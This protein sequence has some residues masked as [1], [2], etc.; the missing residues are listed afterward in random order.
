[1]RFRAMR[2]LGAVSLIGLAATLAMAWSMLG[3]HDVT[4][5]PMEVVD[6]R[7]VPPALSEASAPPA[8]EGEATEMAR[9]VAALR[10][11]CDWPDP[12]SVE[13][14][15]L[16]APPSPGGPPSRIVTVAPSVT[17]LL[18]ALD[19]GARV[20][21]V[22]RFDDYPPETQRLPKVGG[23]LDPSVEAVFGL[24]P[25]LVI[26]VPNAG[27]RAALERMTALGVPVLVV[28]GNT[29]ADVFH[30]TRTV[31]SLFGASNAQR[32]AKLCE[33]V[34]ETLRMLSA[35]APQG[36]HPKVA[37]VYG[38]G[39][40]VLGGRSS[41]A[42][43]LVEAL[44][45]VNV[46]QSGPPYV[47]FSIESLLT[48]SPDVIIDVVDHAV[49]HADS[50]EASADRAARPSILTIWPV[51]KNIKNVRV[52]RLPLG[53][54]LRPSPRLVSAM[55]ALFGALYPGLPDSGASFE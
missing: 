7:T 40:L 47:Q 42:G 11:A 36:A 1:M 18:F 51:L 19:V 13:P 31:G 27:N 26:G 2:L 35:R 34:R 21:G 53:P 6:R 44:G 38:T 45:G 49:D 48:A 39:P 9:A 23:F 43:G 10:A 55:T 8:R 17:E 20:V 24:S 12:P 28:P 4:D 52:R 22:S 29:L 32:A 54:L 50:V 33:D 41:F 37:I 14:Q 3:R 25:D 5:P 46:A 16:R 30:A 15:Y